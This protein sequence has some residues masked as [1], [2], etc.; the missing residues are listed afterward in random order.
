VLVDSRVQVA[1]G[2]DELL[3]S[4]HRLIGPL[5]YRDALPSDQVV[6]GESHTDRQSTL[7]VRTDQPILDPVWKVENLDLEDLALSYMSRAVEQG[8]PKLEVRS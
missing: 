8:Q 7:I 2:I 4:H 5:H 3:A 1:G 6:I